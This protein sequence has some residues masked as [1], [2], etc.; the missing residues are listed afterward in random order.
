MERKKEWERGKRT[1]EEENERGG[2]RNGG[3]GKGKGKRREGGRE[4]LVRKFNTYW[5]R[6]RNFT[7]YI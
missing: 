1:E 2:E 4:G 7:V 6:K 3:T 5:I